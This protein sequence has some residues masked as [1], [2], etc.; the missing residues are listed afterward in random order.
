M[1]SGCRFSCLSVETKEIIKE[2]AGSVEFDLPQKTPA[3]DARNLGLYM[4]IPEGWD[5]TE[6]FLLNF[7]VLASGAGLYFVTVNNK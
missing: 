1:G 6:M 3:N 5:S 2:T 7:G 4:T